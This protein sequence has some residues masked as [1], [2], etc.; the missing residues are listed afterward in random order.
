MSSIY[1]ACV[2]KTFSS[3]HTNI[4]SLCTTKDKRRNYFIKTSFFASS[5]SSV[6]VT[7]TGGI[8]G[9]PCDSNTGVASSTHPLHLFNSPAYYQQTSSPP[10]SSSAQ[11]YSG[12]VPTASY[13]SALVASAASASTHRNT[14]Q[15]LPMSTE[16]DTDPDNNGGNMSP[17]PRDV[18]ADPA[19]ARAAA[20]VGGPTSAALFHTLSGRVQHLMSRVGGGSSANAMNGR[21]LQYIQGIQ[22]SID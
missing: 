16:S 21:L 4:L 14:K 10:P 11:S 5:R 18:L 2:N 12:V 1:Y 9:R 22:V 7:N 8:D 15:S 20:A 13:T 3:P 19:F 6:P 17:T